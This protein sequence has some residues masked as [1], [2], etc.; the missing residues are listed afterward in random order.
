MIAGFLNLESANDG[1]TRTVS[2]FAQEDATGGTETL[3]FQIL[4]QAKTVT[5]VFAANEGK[6]VTVTHTAT[7]TGLVT[8]TATGSAQ[9]SRRILNLD[10]QPKDIGTAVQTA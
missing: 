10:K 2:V 3:Q 7:G 1:T 8:V 5:V 9:T 4:G 6:T